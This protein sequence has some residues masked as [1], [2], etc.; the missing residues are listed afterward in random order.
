[1]KNTL[2]C[3]AAFLLVAACGTATSNIDEIRDRLN[4]N[5][6]RINREELIFQIRELEYL[7]DTTFAEIPQ[8][9]LND[10]LLVCPSTGHHYTMVADGNDRTI[11]CPAGHGESSL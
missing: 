6:C 1:M 5:S 7:Q 2:I 8:F 11:I 9:L 4:E 3:I 10:S